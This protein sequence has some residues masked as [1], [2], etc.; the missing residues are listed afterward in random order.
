[1]VRVRLVRIKGVRIF[2][3]HIIETMPDR[4]VPTRAILLYMHMQFALKSRQVFMNG[5]TYL[6]N[7]DDHE[8]NGCSSLWKRRPP[9]CASTRTTARL[10]SSRRCPT[11]CND[12]SQPSL[13]QW[14]ASL[15]EYSMCQLSD[16]HIYIERDLDRFGTKSRRPELSRRVGWIPR[17]IIVYVLSL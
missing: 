8:I 14:L 5:S 4:K 12:S 6:Q 15:L 7:I 2:A 17:S 9:S 16:L 1:M 13:D 3:E 10:A 11:S